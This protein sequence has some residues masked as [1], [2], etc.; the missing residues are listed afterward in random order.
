ML[1]VAGVRDDGRREILA[2]EAVD[3][4]SEATDHDFF[5]RRKA[6]SARGR[7]G[8]QRQEAC[9]RIPW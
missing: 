9:R 3:T 1:V 8:D 5:T 4:E 7:V 6:R 2:V